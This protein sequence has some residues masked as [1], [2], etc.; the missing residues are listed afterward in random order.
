MLTRIARTLTLTFI[1]L[2]ILFSAYWSGIDYVAMKRESLT[3]DLIIQ[4][5]DLAEA[6]D[7]SL[8]MGD[9]R[10]VNWQA[11]GF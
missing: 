3:P 6:L 10:R 11:V 8:Q 9:G 5:H 4:P 1:F 7:L 2:A